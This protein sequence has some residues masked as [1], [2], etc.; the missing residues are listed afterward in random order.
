[1]VF[2]VGIIARASLADGSFASH[3]TAIIVSACLL[4]NFMNSHRLDMVGAD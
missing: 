2:G 1:M 3:L 4:K